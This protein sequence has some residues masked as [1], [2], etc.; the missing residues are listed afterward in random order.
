M[1]NLEYNLTRQMQTRAMGQTKL[2]FLA[3][4]N[5]FVLQNGSLSLVSFTVS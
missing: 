1:F 5:A 3:A 4:L 2:K